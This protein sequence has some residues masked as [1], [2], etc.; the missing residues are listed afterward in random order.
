MKSVIFTFCLLCFTA[1]LCA[2]DETSTFSAAAQTTYGSYNG[3]S[4]RKSL[5]TEAVTLGYATDNFGATATVRNWKLCRISLL[6]DL[7]GIDT[8]VS[9]YGWRKIGTAGSVGATAAVNYLTGNDS[10]TNRKV[11]PY[12]AITYKTHD[13]GQYVD[14]GYAQMGYSDTTVNQLS[15]TWGISLLDRYV[16]AQTR[17]YYGNLSTQLQ[18]KGQTTAVE[19]R[20]SWYV[21]PSTLT[22]TLSGMVGQRV[23]GYDPDLKM[24]Y[25]LS[26][27]QKGSVGLTATWQITPALVLFGDVT[28]ATYEKRS[29]NNS[30]SAVFGTVGLNFNF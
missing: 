24:T 2:A 4:E 1:R 8:N 21:V 3:S 15:A 13:G 11:V 22:L 16:W 29:I 28:S 23:Y 5:L 27:I 6:G 30:Y 12:G 18:G 25:T 10:N 19:E 17:L 9:L 14:V 7:S 20:L 26:D